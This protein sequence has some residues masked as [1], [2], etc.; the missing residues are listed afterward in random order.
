MQLSSHEPNQLCAKDFT[1]NPKR[2]PSLIEARDLYPNDNLIIV[3]MNSTIEVRVFDRSDNCLQE[4]VL[5]G[6]INDKCGHSHTHNFIFH[7]LKGIIDNIADENF[8]RDIPAIVA[9]GNCVDIFRDSCLFDE[10][11]P[12]ITS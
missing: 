6:I 12:T 9:T 4:F 8:G 1:F 7:G 11:I 3:D 2:L 5:D 10:I